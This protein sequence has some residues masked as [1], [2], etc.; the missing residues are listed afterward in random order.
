MKSKT[1][2]VLHAIGH[3]P[4]VGHV[5][6][7]VA[8]LHPTTCVVV[9]GPDTPA[10]ADA[11]APHPT[12]IQQD[13]LGT[14]HAVM[15]A[16]PKVA[17]VTTGTVLV[18]FGDTPLITAATAQR[19]VTAREAEGA[20]VV[21]LGFEAVDPSGYGRLVT[22][23]GDLRAIVEEKDADAETKAITLC[24]AGLMAFDAALLPDFLDQLT[25]ENAAGEYYLTDVVAIAQNQRR[26]ASYVVADEDEVMGV[27]NRA[28]LAEA[29][30]IFQDRKR[31]A[32]MLGGA[33]LHAPETVFFAHDTR[34]GRDVIIEPNVV[35]G[36]GVSVADDVMIHAFSHLEGA[37][38]ASGATVGPYA[39]LRPGADLAENTKVG[40]FVEIKKAT[41]EPG[42]K[43]NH[44]TYIGDARV[45]EKANIGAG[46]ITCNYDGFN[47]SFTDIGAGAFIGSNS[48]LVAPVTIGDGAIVGAGSTI[49]ESVEANALAVERAKVSE[50]A[51]WATRFR[52]AQ[53]R[54]K[55]KKS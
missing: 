34:L 2:K 25:N 22:S 20:A 45:G 48:A 43:V 26:K 8:P 4:M 39:R 35:F 17:T 29:E 10:I 37:S 46:T 19:L 12:V 27:N 24:N 55:A 47:K 7:A 30:A 38:V 40:N 36:P 33:T 28:Q 21:V 31:Q 13:R 14:G 5:L 41:L 50:L 11:V 32:A 52:K 9:S 53:A 54:R 3:K 42:A 16:M 15:A 51:G 1:P 23:G 44:L 6:D 18:L 49:T